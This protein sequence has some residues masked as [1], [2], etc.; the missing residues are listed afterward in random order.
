MHTAYQLLIAL[1]IQSKIDNR[2]IAIHFSANR[3]VHTYIHRQIYL[4]SHS[5]SPTV[6]DYLHDR[7]PSNKKKREQYP[8]L[9]IPPALVTITRPACLALF[10]L[11]NQI[12]HHLPYGTP[13]PKTQLTE[14]V[15][16]EEKTNKKKSKAKKGKVGS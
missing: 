5:T 14:Y 3:P 8:S 1:L 13:H 7:A 9:V 6:G 15:L 4:V 2:F 16:R 10:A 12:L 11:P